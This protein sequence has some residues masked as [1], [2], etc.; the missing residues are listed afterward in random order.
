[1]RTSAGRP[2]GLHQLGLPARR[3]PHRPGLRPQ[4]PGRAAAGAPDLAPAHRLR[5]GMTTMQLTGTI[6]ADSLM[7]LEAYAKWRKQHKADVIAHRKLRSV[8]LGEHLTV[9]FESEMTMR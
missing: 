6:T 5:T 8:A 3:P 2:A 4:R 7:T 1:G 9:Q